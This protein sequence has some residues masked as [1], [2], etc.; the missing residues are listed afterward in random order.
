MSFLHGE[1]YLNHQNAS[2]EIG[3]LIC[4]GTIAKQSYVSPSCYSWKKFGM[5]SG[6]YLVDKKPHQKSM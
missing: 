6:Y 3:P 5:P 1:I 4:K 2:V